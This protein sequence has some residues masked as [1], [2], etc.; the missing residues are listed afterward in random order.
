MLDDLRT[1][2]C[3]V[4]PDEDCGEGFG[5]LSQTGLIIPGEAGRGDIANRSRVNGKDWGDDGSR[6]RSEHF[7][8]HVRVSVDV[9]RVLV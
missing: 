9:A 1:S 5:G 7:G 4:C 8:I 3:L 2:E 6:C